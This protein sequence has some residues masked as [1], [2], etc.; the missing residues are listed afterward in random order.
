MV[1]VLAEEWSWGAII[2]LPNFCTHCHQILVHHSTYHHLLKN[3]TYTRKVN[4]VVLVTCAV[5]NETNI[6]YCHIIQ[7]KNT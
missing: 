6:T 3:T 1:M 2:V 7:T 5:A 4:T